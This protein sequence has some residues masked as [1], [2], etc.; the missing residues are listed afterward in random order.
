MKNI[1]HSWDL[2]IALYSG[3]MFLD[4]KKCLD[5]KKKMFF[6]KICSLK[7]NMFQNGSSM[8]WHHYATPFLEPFFKSVNS[9][10]P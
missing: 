4:Y 7:M 10:V 2:S 5:T 1:Q 8:P 9:F 6:F 3:T